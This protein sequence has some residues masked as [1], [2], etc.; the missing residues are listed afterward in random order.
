MLA[1]AE[2][3]AE[4]LSRLDPG[5]PPGCLV[6]RLCGLSIFLTC[7]SSLIFVFPSC[8]SELIQGL[9]PPMEE[10]R[11]ILEK[12]REREFVSCPQLCLVF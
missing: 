8:K 7:Q 12:E 2:R 1:R 10:E 5:L 3:P 6:L 4:G 9:L 11:V